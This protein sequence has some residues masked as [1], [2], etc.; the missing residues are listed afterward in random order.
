MISVPYA[1]TFTG[2]KI[3]IPDQPNLRYAMV[4][5]IDYPQ[6]STDFYGKPCLNTTGSYY[7]FSYLTL[8][9]NSVEIIHNLPIMELKCTNASTTTG[10]ITNRNINGM[11]SFNG[12]K[13]DWTKSY[14]TVPASLAPGVDS[15]YVLGV[16]YF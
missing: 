11:L 10:L 5:A 14:F 7:A 3:K 16:W 1:A 8:V 13:I 15:V 12:Q 2:V 6:I 4:Q 9:Y